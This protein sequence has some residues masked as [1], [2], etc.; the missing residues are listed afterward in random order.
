MI[1]KKIEKKKKDWSLLIFLIFAVVLLFSFAQ[2][3]WFATTI[4][5]R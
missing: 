2:A 1:D 4:P 5:F 3:L